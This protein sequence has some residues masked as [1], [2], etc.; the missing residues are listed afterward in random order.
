MVEQC[1]F[2]VI[3][4]GMYLCCGEQGSSNGFGVLYAFTAPQHK[5]SSSSVS[6]QTP[7]EYWQFISTKK[8]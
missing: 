3:A 4:Y 2:F 8:T 5:I 6:H 1:H 7:T